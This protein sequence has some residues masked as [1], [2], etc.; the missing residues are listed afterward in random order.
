MSMYLMHIGIPNILVPALGD[1]MT[2][3]FTKNSTNHLNYPIAIELSKAAKSV[4]QRITK[5]NTFLLNTL[6]RT[7]VKFVIF[8]YS[9]TIR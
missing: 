5:K 2:I 9:I 8:P 3:L 7:T 1:R 4:G 6:V